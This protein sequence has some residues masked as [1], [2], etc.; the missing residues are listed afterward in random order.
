M[1]TSSVLIAVCR[2]AGR[3]FHAFGSAMLNARLPNLSR[4]HGT[5]IPSSVAEQSDNKVLE[6][7]YNPGIM[8]TISKRRT[9]WPGH[10]VCWL[11]SLEFVSRRKNVRKKRCE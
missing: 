10:T 9:A 4:E 5:S 8:H 2:S 1:K 6:K 11:Q 7:I 3:L